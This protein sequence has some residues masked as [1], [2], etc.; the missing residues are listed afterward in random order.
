MVFGIDQ[1][2]FKEVTNDVPNSIKKE[3]G[4]KASQKV[5]FD[6]VLIDDGSPYAIDDSFYTWHLYLYYMDRL[7]EEKMD[8]IFTSSI[9]HS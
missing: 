4:Y 5:T 8:K 6:L 9:C 7:E 2:H 1:T 3:F